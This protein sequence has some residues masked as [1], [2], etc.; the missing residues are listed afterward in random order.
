[1]NVLSK[2]FYIVILFTPYELGVAKSIASTFRTSKKIAPLPYPK[3]YV[4]RKA[5]IS[6]FPK[7]DHLIRQAGRLTIK[8]KQLT[9]E[10]LIEL[11]Y[12]VYNPETPVKEKDIFA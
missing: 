5:K 2:R 10:E 8:L 4:I 6:L 7:R 1:M 3:S 12:N 9:T 11:F